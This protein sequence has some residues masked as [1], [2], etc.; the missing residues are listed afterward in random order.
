MVVHA[1]R[2]CKSAFEVCVYV[3]WRLCECCLLT[4]CAVACVKRFSDLI[5]HPAELL[6]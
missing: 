2:V 6:L 5:K 4:D 1:A 3:L